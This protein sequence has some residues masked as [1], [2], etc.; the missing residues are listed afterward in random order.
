MLM[1]KDYLYFRK[2]RWLLFTL[3]ALLT[4]NESGVGTFMSINF[5]I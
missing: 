1:K 4:G 5:I 3:L 2:S